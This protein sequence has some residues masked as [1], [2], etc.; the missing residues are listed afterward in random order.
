MAERPPESSEWPTHVDIPEQDD[1]EP[2]PDPPETDKHD[3]APISD[4]MARQI[5]DMIS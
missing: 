4:A 1:R 3:N 2:T 5:R